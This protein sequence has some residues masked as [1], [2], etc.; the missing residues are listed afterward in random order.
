MQ[1][2]EKNW[3]IFS[4]YIFKVDYL[5]NKSIKINRKYMLLSQ[6]PMVYCFV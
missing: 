2:F 5:M 1:Y 3:G 6:I 4:N